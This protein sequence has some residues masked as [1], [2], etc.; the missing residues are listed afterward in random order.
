MTREVDD[1]TFEEVVLRGPS[2][3]ISAAFDPAAPKLFS[4]ARRPSS[5][6]NC[7]YGHGINFVSMQV[8]SEARSHMFGLSDFNE[9]TAGIV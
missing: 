7:G 1:S 3:R 2:W 9:I 6:R 4:N 8:Q 5:P